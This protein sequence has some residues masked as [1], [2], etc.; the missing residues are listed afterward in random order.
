MG[1]PQEGD[2][3]QGEEEERVG[4]AAA[5]VAPLPDAQNCASSELRDPTG[6]TCRQRARA[7][8]SCEQ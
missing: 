3:D 8:T 7:V 4:A 2:C 5:A 6:R 1:A